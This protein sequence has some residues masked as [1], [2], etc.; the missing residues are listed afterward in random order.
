[1]AI[2]FGAV[3]LPLLSYIGWQSLHGSWDLNLLGLLLVATLAGTVA[4]I[5][6]ISAL[7]AP[8]QRATEMLH[9]V[10]AGGHVGPVPLGGDDLVGRLLHGVA[11]AASETA[12]RME[13]LKDAA[14]RDVLTGLRNRRG[15]L[16]AAAPILNSGKPAVIAVIDLDHFKAVNDD[17]GHDRGDELLEDFADHL[18]SELRRSDLLARWGGEEFMV[19]FPNTEP[20]QAHDILQLLQRAM[21]SA[22]RFDM[23]GKHLTFSCGL[24][25]VASYAELKMAMQRADTSLYAAKKAGRDRIIAA[26]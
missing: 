24:A 18:V 9:V 4:A 3:H 21:R 5:L 14:E 7:L 20:S 15:F 13:Q 10:Q 19:L 16:D 26:R 22:S 12:R 1:M 8:I 11:Q 25:S 17:Y 23:E 2:C 6:A